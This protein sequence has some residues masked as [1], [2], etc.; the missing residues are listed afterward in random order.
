MRERQTTPPLSVRLVAALDVVGGLAILV[1][2]FEDPVTRRMLDATLFHTAGCVI[3]V[4]LGLALWRRSHFARVTHFVV[5]AFVLGFAIRPRSRFGLDD[6]DI[7]PTAGTLLVVGLLLL[8]SARAWF[9]GASESRRET[10]AQ[11]RRRL[12]LHVS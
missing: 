3:S 10:R 4:L 6:I 5:A 1:L 2:L 8:P 9:A 11:R 7:W 12:A